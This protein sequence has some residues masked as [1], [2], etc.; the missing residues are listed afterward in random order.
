MVAPF[1]AAGDSKGNIY[2]VDSAQH[3]VQ[4]F[5]P[6][7]QYLF[8]FGELGLASGLLRHPRAIAVDGNDD[9]YVA[10][11]N[12]IQKFDQNGNPLLSL[13]S[14]FTL[15]TGTFTD[16]AVDRSGKIY[17]ISKDDASFCCPSVYCNGASLVISNSAG[18]ILETWQMPGTD[19][20]LTAVAVDSD[21][22]I[23]IGVLDHLNA[24]TSKSFLLKLDP[25]LNI[26]K[27]LYE[28]FMDDSAHRRV[29]YGLDVDNYDNVYAAAEHNLFIFDA[30]GNPSAGIYNPYSDN[31][32]FIQP[33]GVAVNSQGFIYITGSENKKIYKYEPNITPI[34]IDLTNTSVKEGLPVNTPRR[35]ADR[36]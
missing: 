18:Q 24:F 25:D 33:S 20:E 32:V 31:G 26:V 3:R 7:G 36:H 10:S 28:P 4:K 21:D 1:D 35:N 23:Y 2:V 11:S 6:Y 14:E 29:V 8:S 13:F 15:W 16:I 19:P 9:I 27:D 12:G 17:A 34:D 30:Q 22:N 5:D